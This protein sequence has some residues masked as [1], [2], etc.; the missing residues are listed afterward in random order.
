ME[1]DC[2]QSLALH[3]TPGSHTICALFIFLPMDAG[4]RIFNGTQ[5]CER[6]INYTS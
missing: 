4:D 2:N 3:I 6:A 5:S 1:E